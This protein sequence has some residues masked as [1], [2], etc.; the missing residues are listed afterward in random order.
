MDWTVSGFCLDH[1][2]AVDVT[3][4]DVPGWRW[5]WRWNISFSYLVVGRVRYLIYISMRH[6]VNYFR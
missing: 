1:E 6:Y 2:S 3:V 5:R 4:N